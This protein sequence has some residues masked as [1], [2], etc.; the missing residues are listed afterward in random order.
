MVSG[1]DPKSDPPIHI[2]GLTLGDNDEFRSLF[3]RGAPTTTATGPAGTSIEAVTHELLGRSCVSL[4]TKGLA[5]LGRAELVLTVSAD[6]LAR[7][8]SGPADVLKAL[9]AAPLE[10]P[11]AT[12]LGLASSGRASRRSG[13]RRRRPGP[14]A[15]AATRAG[16]SRDSMVRPGR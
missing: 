3:G 16:I 12:G 10:I 11:S 4:V 8:T 9:T 15:A 7:A 5:R 13:R 1:N 14:V 2:D 6:V